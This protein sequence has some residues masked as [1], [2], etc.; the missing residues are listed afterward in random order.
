MNGVETYDAQSTS[1]SIGMVDLEFT[2]RTSLVVEPSDGRIPP[3]TPE[4][5][6]RESTVATGW[7]FKTGPEDLNNVHRCITTGVPRLGGNFGAGP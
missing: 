3:L 2:N 7:R 5:Q 4:A 1:S 6:A